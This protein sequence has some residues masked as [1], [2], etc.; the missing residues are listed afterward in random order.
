M[1]QQRGSDP[2]GRLPAAF[3][4]PGS[5]SFTDFVRDHAPEVLPGSRPLPAGAVP[6]HGGPFTGGPGGGQPPHATTIVAIVCEAGVVMAG[7]RR[8]TAGNMIAQRDIEKVF[9]ADDHSCVGIAGTAGLA[10]EMVRLFQVEL[11]HFEKLEGALMSF[12]GKAN[13]LSTMIRGNLGLAL[14]GLAVVPVF[15]GYDL[16]AGRGRIVSYDVTGGRYEEVDHHSVGSGSVFA[17]GALKKLFR[18]GM[19]AAAAVRVAVEALWD[20]ADDDSATGGPDLLR[21]IWPVVTVVTAQGYQRVTDAEVAA[22]VDAVVA[23]RRGNPGGRP[24]ESTEGA[25][26]A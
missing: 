3:H 19:S 4:V 26:G 21:G 17:R 1:S 6:A 22:V 10:L 20:A 16:E 14:Q 2:S 9:P 15:A 24:Q 13:R 8:A 23:N 25:S 11:E 5:S 18:P 12:E 7:D